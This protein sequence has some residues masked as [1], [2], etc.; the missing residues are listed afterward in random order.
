[1]PQPHAQTNPT[2]H[3]L[4]TCRC[5][6]H[7]MQQQQR[8]YVNSTS[9]RAF[10]QPLL[11]TTAEDEGVDGAMWSGARGLCIMRRCW[12]WLWAF[13]NSF[14]GKSSVWVPKKL[15]KVFLLLVNCER[16]DAAE[17]VDVT[18]WGVLVMWAAYYIAINLTRMNNAFDFFLLRSRALLVWASGGGAVESNQSQRELRG[19]VK[20]VSI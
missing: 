7:C 13:L 11:L 17:V 16:W 18:R 15:P 8:Q 20:R 14:I 12:V 5:W 6:F 4:G 19:F 9:L 3:F 1:M 2:A 10:P